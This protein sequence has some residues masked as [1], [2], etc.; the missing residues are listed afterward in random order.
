MSDTEST[1]SHPKVQAAIDAIDAVYSDT[2]V[3][4]EDTF[5]RMCELLTDIGERVEAMDGANI[6]IVATSP[7]GNEFIR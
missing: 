4:V 7:D 3:P 6:R 1:A 2:S 5:D